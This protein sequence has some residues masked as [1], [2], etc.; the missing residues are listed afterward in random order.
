MIEL[1][2]NIKLTGFRELDSGS[3][4][5]LKKIIGSYA[6]KLSDNSKEFEGL[7]LTL[8]EIS[9]THPKYEVR[10]KVLN[11]GAVKTSEVTDRNLFVSVDS[12]LKKVLSIIKK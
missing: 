4:V 12:S 7:E 3:M 10:S 5:I 8:K 6:R 2:G 11:G 9:G 1:G